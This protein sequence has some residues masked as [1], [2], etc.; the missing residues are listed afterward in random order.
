MTKEDPLD[1]SSDEVPTGADKP[2]YEEDVRLKLFMRKA[3]A[4]I[5]SERGFNVASRL[6]LESLAQHQKLPDNLFDEAV[7]Q[8]QEQDGQSTKVTRYEKEFVRYLAR[9]LEK[10]R[11]G[12]LSIRMEQ[13]AIELAE[14][15]YQ[16][17]STRAEYLI[18][19]QAEQASIARVSRSDSEEYATQLIVERIGSRREIDNELH[20]ELHQSGERLGLSTE[21]I[22]QEILRL[23]KANRFEV[24][25][26]SASLNWVLA[27]MMLVILVGV[28]VVASVSMGWIKF[29]DQIPDPAPMKSTDPAVALAMVPKPIWLSETSHQRVLELDAGTRLTESLLNEDVEQRRLG[30]QRLVELAFQD[31][32]EK[33]IQV[34]DVV[35]RLFY[36][37][38]D[39]VAAFAIV[40][41]A[42]E[43]ARL[44][45][46]EQSISMEAFQS[47]RY[48]NRI[49]ALIYYFS[50][51]ELNSNASADLKKRKR[52]LAAVVRAGS[53]VDPEQVPF[54]ELVRQSEFGLSVDQWSYLIQ[55]TWSSPSRAAIMLQPTYEMTQSSLPSGSLKTFRKR[56]L[57][58]ILELDPSQWA[59]LRIP[60]RESVL[61]SDEFGLIDWVDLYIDTS[62]A[63]FR[64]YVGPLL[65]EKAGIK[66][67]T[68]RS[69]EVAR[70]IEAYSREFRT[71]M[72]KPLL[73]RNKQIE[74]ST[75][76]LLESIQTT[77]P[78]VSPDLIA[79]IAFQAN[80]NLAMTKQIRSGEF[81]HDDDFLDLD[82]LLTLEKPR[83]RELV[84]LP[85]ASGV[86]PAK[87]SPTASDTNRKNSALDMIGSLEPEDASKR[88]L[89]LGQLE[90]IAARF[91]DL[92]YQEGAVLAR[93]FLAELD[94]AEA[95]NIQRVISSFADW[96]M[97][98]LAIADQIALGEIGIDK[99]LTIARLYFGREF[100]IQSGEKNW[101]ST[102]QLEM[103]EGIAE[104]IEI[105]LDRDPNNMKSDWIRLELYLA[106]IYRNRFESLFDS[107]NA[108][109]LLD[110]IEAGGKPSMILIAMLDHY[111][112]KSQ[113]TAAS[114]NRMTRG[115]R[116]IERGRFNE[117]EKTIMASQ[118]VFEMLAHE[119]QQSSTQDVAVIQSLIDETE[120][121]LLRRDVL[122][123]QL[124]EI[125]LGLLRLSQLKRQA[126]IRNITQ[127]R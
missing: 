102:L 25:R 104:Q 73:T 27:A 110:S 84:S 18:Q 98:G 90:K 41:T 119:T 105:R 29:A 87:A 117:L 31:S 107:P 89:A 28:G 20:A 15:K 65:L 125:N 39:E 116:L 42:S 34:E 14:S 56:L 114:E 26:S 22:D 72:L 45:E 94:D 120:S 12:V 48:S 93:Y 1:S 123:E 7:R 99:S 109:E 96:P 24:V 121:S 54:S 50:S 21:R 67:T 68:K 57:Q 113:P 47:Q 32:Y 17:N 66:L 4:V 118:L 40:E 112:A 59:Q 100:E 77:S 11:G 36:E 13:N 19:E 95:L 78:S 53:G 63:G 80:V 122:A 16:I 9:E 127:Q 103:L 64:D 101:R 86:A 124:L 52:R 75:N 38:P 58:T 46:E 85:G 61:A 51:T 81:R 108:P 106:G 92:A 111:L 83:L 88:V 62:Q 76:D 69:T 74:I 30:Y 35:C 6:K 23:L 49:L 44:P 70:A 71:R 3:V 79:Q 55:N 10:I 115:K 8:L 2:S 91:D 37:D 5:A 82:R 97:L 33:R 126:M 43:F 60:I